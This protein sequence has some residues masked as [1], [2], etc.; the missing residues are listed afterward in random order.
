MLIKF[1][2]F[3]ADSIL[4]NLRTAPNIKTAQKFYEMG[5]NFDS[6]CITHF[7]IYLS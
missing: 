6:F 5:L 2:Q 4:L 7:K 1:C 3:I